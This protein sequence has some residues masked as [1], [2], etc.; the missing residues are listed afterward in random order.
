MGWSPLAAWVM[1]EPIGI[2]T[3][4]AP[5]AI[6]FLLRKNLDGLPLPIEYEKIYQ[7]WETRGLSRGK[8]KKYLL[9][10]MKWKELPDIPML[11][12]LKIIREYLFDIR[13]KKE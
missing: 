8:L 6:K 3:I 2:I 4:V 7:K 1:R 9:K 12:V 10:L 5:S 13:E 11:E